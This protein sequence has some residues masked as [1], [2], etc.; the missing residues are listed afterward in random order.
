MTIEQKNFIET[1]GKLA[2]ADMQKSGIPASLTIAQAILESGWGKSG[3]TVKANALFGI[4]ASSTWAGKVYSSDTKECYDGIN[5]TT[6]TALFRAYDSWAESVTDHSALLTGAARYADI[7]GETDY[8]KACE[9][10]ASAGYATDPSY[11]TK[12]ITLIETYCLHEYDSV[13]Q[14]LKGDGKMTSAEFVKKL[15]NVVENYKTVYMWGTFGSPVTESII[16]Q[17]AGQYPT[18]Y[19]TTKQSA[20]RALIGKGY[21]GF[22]CVGL[23]KG[24]LWGW[25][26]DKSKTYGGATYES[27]NVPDISA[28]TMITKCSGVSTDFNDIV[29][30]EAVWMK[31]H[32]GV[33][34]GNGK[35]IESTSSWSSGVQITALGNIGTISGLNSRKWE[36]HG[37]LP[38]IEYVEAA[39]TTATTSSTATS[40]SLRLGDIVQFAGGNV[41]ASANTAKATST[42]SPSKCKVTQT[43]NGSHPYHLI[44]EDGG[45][46]YGWVDTANVSLSIEGAISRLDELEI[47]PAGFSY[48]LSNYGK[49]EYLDQLL[50]NSA[51]KITSKGAAKSTVAEAVKALASA[52]ISSSPDYWTQN[53]SKLRY[54]EDL[55]KALGG[56]V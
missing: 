51:A 41:Y 52:G 31:G 13:K 2:T 21:F 7:V 36:K 1:V 35:V 43:Y 24:L 40:T 34:I 39:T 50:I 23:I 17:K 32:I 19:N 14:E 6:I 25:V 56:S 10:I 11:D 44:S 9:A 49:L 12:L 37:K 46:V 5:F 42:K 29:A 47:L 27:N 55:L 18:S 30:G 22:D 45:G 28:D 33:Y 53:Y 4:K 54:L 48:W 8:T 15:E 38:Y 16:A 3:L 26:G 20:L